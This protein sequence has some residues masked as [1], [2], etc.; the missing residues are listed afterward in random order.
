LLLERRLFVL[1]AAVFTATIVGSG[2]WL[3]GKPMG[4]HYPKIECKELV[5]LTIPADRIGLPTKGAEIKS[6]TMVPAVP[7]TVDAKGNIVLAVPEYCKVLGAIAPVDPKAFPINFEI[8]LSTNWNYRS[9]QFGGGGFNGSIVP[10]AGNRSPQPPNAP[11]PL[12]R[13]YVT[14]GS[15]S[16]QTGGNAS[17]G[18]N[19]E[20]LLNF[21][22]ESLKKTK[23]TAFYVIEKYYG[24]V[25]KYS[26]FNGL[27]NG[28]REGHT[29]TQR[30]PND[31]DG[32]IAV[33]PILSHE[34]AHIHDNAMLTAFAPSPGGGG[35]M[36]ENKIKLI[37]DS[38]NALCDANDGL[39]DGIISK[40]GVLDPVLG[41]HAACQHDVAD[42]L[43]PGGKDLGDQCLSAAQVAAVKVIRDRFTLGFTLPNG[44]DGY[45]GYGA[46]GSE[47]NDWSTWII[48][49]Q[50]PPVPQPPRVWDLVEYGVG[51]IPYY[52]HTDVRYFIVQDPNF[53]TYNFDPLAYE[54]RIKYVSSLMASI[55]PDISAFINKGGKLIMKDNTA[56]YARSVFLGINYYKSLVD[57]FGEE[58]VEQSVRLYVAVGANHRGQ[59][60]PSE[61]DLITLLE[62][63]VEKQ[64]APPKNI[65]GVTMG[66]TNF[67]VTA[68][69]P[70]CGYG[71]YPRYNGSGDPNDASSFT[72]TPLEE[73]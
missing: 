20:A 60:A 56:D 67:K 16:G 25:P 58:A 10:T 43:C 73:E 41:W 62:D 65:I 22:Y 63:W 27:S 44:N 40:Y 28:A 29:V 53:Q 54:S 6:A 59:F 52:G 30:F 34:V 39:E 51:I 64:K 57:K 19:K 18:T 36:N 61:A 71:L 1:A 50:P 72:C 3:Y 35:W 47:I 55:N 37:N 70:M 4:Q 66:P 26:Y 46:M 14:F 23:D 7:Q 68:S 8:D 17:F 13:G 2:S 38:T 33:V 21:A 9:M 45:V 24:K 69:R 32:V 15:D 31:Y 12:A 49:R 5:G 42:L 11:V 48:G